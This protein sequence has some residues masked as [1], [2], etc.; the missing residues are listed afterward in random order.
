MNILMTGSSGP[1][2]GQVVAQ[3]LARRHALVGVDLQPGKNTRHLADI[4]RVKDWR[5]LM[6]GMDAVVHFA[7]LHAPHRTTHTRAHFEA[8]NVEA[9]RKLLEAAKDSGVRRF[10]FAS[11]TSAYGHALRPRDRAIWVTEELPSIAEDIYDETK[12]AAEALCREFHDANFR[13]MALRFSRCFPEPLERMVV[14]RLYRGVDAHD[15]AGAF[16][17]AVNAEFDA[18]EIFNISGDTPFR[19]EDCEELFRDAP[20]VLARREPALVEAY[21]Q[22]GWQLPKSI[23]RVYAIDKA[24]VKLA[25]QPRYGWRELAVG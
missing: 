14:Y 8:T 22:H 13:V 19:P 6:R 2:V 24:K 9:T 25:Y 12:L 1:K 23:D 10:V 20:G 11:S 4:S 7:A 17:H 3:E 18:F 21:A 15:V 16:L 5:P